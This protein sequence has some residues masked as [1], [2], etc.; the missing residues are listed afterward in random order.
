METTDT[1]KALQ[2]KNEGNDY[3]KKKDYLN[4]IE[5]YSKAIST[6]PDLNFTN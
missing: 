5:S 3:F 4:A 1:E 6:Y 2:Y